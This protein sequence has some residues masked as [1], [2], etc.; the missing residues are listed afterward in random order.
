MPGKTYQ[1]IRIETEEKVAILTIDQPPVNAIT[2]ELLVDLENAFDDLRERDGVRVVIL[3]AHG[4]ASFVA[5][6]DVN[7]LSRKDFASI[8]NYLTKI[9]ST[10]NKIEE[11]PKPVI[12]AVNGHAAGNGCELSMV[13]D[14]RVVNENATFLFPEC[15]FGVVSAGGTTFRLPRL[16]PRGRALHYL[17]TAERMSA[18]EALDLGFA[19]F[20]K[21]SD[22]L[23]PFSREMAFKIAENAPLTVASIKKLVRNGQDMPADKALEEELFMSVESCRTNDFIEGITAYLE[24][25]VPVFNGS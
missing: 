5:G 9:H 1:T 25:R 14:I 6:A 12:C 19:D 20:V 17:F 22:E 3:T 8:K 13:C 7:V 10:F 4:P 21:S 2:E 16:I 11:F 24:K 18:G 15:R 23:L